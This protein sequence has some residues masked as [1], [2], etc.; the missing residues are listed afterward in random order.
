VL[1]H[2]KERAGPSRR[3]GCGSDSAAGDRTTYAYDPANRLQTVETD[4]GVTSY[5]YDANG[6]QRTI[7]QPNGDVTTQT[8]D[9]ENRMIQVEHPSGDMVTLMY[10]PDGHRVAEDDGVAVK[11]FVYD[12]NTLLQE[13][14]D[15][16]AVEADYTA[17]P[18]AY[19]LM[20]SQHRDADSSFY[21]TNGIADVTQL[22][23][24]TQTVTDDYRHGAWGN[25]VSSTGSTENPHTFKGE[26][27]A[28]CHWRRLWAASAFRVGSAA[29]AGHRKTVRHFHEP[30]DLHELTFSCYRRQPLLTNDLWRQLFC[31]AVDRAI[32]RHQFRLVAF[33]VMPEHVHLLVFPTR[34]PPNIDGLLSA[35]KR[36]YSGRIKRILK[37]HGSPLLQR[38]TVTER[39]GKRVFRFWQE[40]PGYDRNLSHERS[41]LAAIDYI[42]HNPVRRGLVRHPVDW[43]WSSARWYA[44]EGQQLDADL[45]TI[46]GLPPEFFT[47]H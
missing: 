35:I 19:G 14:D 46:H 1:Q 4:A 45:P 20:L 26:I 40:G 11:E 34:E 16:G 32:A 42:H 18:Q 22:A 2:R 3:T 39:P 38:L 17:V 6:N 30:G 27:G 31:Q 8:W 37:Q 10:D 13:R 9:F 47:S 15:V 24:D 23:D 12:G 33:V 29:M 36:P 5:T 41:V 21:L 28:G 7:E 44:S 25:L 43:K